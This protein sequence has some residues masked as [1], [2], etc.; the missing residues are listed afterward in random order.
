MEQTPSGGFNPHE[1]I[2]GSYEPKYKKVADLPEVI[3][4]N[5]VDLPE[6]GFVRKTAKDLYDKK[7]EEYKKEGL[8]SRKDL[9][10][11]M[12]RQ[13][14]EGLVVE[15]TDL[16][17]RKARAFI[18]RFFASKEKQA[19][20]LNNDVVS[21]IRQDEG[22][23]WNA[24]TEFDLL[25]KDADNMKAK[26]DD[27][28]ILSYWNLMESKLSE[29]GETGYI[30][31]DK[32]GT[33]LIGEI[34]GVKINIKLQKPIHPGTLPD[35][36]DYAEIAGEYFEKDYKRPPLPFD[37]KDRKIINMLRKYVPIALNKD[38]YER[39]LDLRK[40]GVDRR[41]EENKKRPINK[42][43]TT[44]LSKEE[45]VAATKRARKYMYLDGADKDIRA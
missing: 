1:R 44:V 42:I 16:L 20:R 27:D 15:P 30:F 18:D 17:R 43:R 2:D 33:R 38:N 10:G 26:L 21:K 32:E 3:R 19:E 23:R 9:N 11:R 37:E 8:V 25:R 7:E 24:Q 41:L 4:R 40:K 39:E 31:L 14:K 29:L 22:E 12:Y 5:Y 36:Y 35:D 6:G 45:D 13:K 28:L 34:D